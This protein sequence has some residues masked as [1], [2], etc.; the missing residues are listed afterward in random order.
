[1][2]SLDFWIPLHWESLSSSSFCKSSL[3]PE[4]QLYRLLLDVGEDI[5]VCKSKELTN[6][7]RETIFEG[8]DLVYPRHM[9][10]RSTKTFLE[11][12]ECRLSFVLIIVAIL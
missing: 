9:F 5:E 10:S 4:S 6:V 1:M 8:F 12:S 3:R 2:Q 11:L 7:W